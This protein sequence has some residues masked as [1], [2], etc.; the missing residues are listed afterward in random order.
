MTG[1]SFPPVPELRVARVVEA[2][3]HP[4][5]DR[6]LVMR[7]DLGG[8]ERQIV[9]GIRD[10]YHAE[11]LVGKEIVVVAN[12]QP[13]KLRGEWSQAMLLATEDEGGRLGILLAPGAAAGTRVAP[14]SGQPPDGEITFEGFH[15]NVLMATPE[16]VFLNGQPLEGAALVMDRSVY[17]RLK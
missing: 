17:G 14:S 6:L 16:G 12:L 13:A 10:H 8:E 1:T 9:A 7:I 5:A 11:E 4:N 15:E 3:N 2:R